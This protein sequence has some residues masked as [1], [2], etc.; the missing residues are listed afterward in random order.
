MSSVRPPTVS[1]ATPGPGASFPL[2]F[3]APVTV[4]PPVSVCPA[5]TV[6]PS[7]SAVKSRPAPL[8]TL[9]VALLAMETPLATVS[10]PPAT[11][12]APL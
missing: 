7:G 6:K 10:V 5:L 11:V 4:P 1:V 2:R 12:V 9:I 8:A 3:T